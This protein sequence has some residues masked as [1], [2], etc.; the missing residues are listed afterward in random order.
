MSFKGCRTLNLA[1]CL[2][3]QLGGVIMHSYCFM[4]NGFEFWTC[5]K[6]CSLG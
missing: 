4:F 5:V 1:K 6:G 2:V 3:M